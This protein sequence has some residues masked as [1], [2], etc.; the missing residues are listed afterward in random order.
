MRTRIKGSG[1]NK[2]MEGGKK[3]EEEEK[4]EAKSE[5][6]QFFSPKFVLI[7]IFLLHPI[8]FIHLME[9]NYPVF[10]PFSFLLFPPCLLLVTI[11]LSKQIFFVWE[12]ET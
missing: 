7:T 8:F 12:T 6:I 3:E 1:G 10:F 9:C 11:L 5:R 4:G 2:A